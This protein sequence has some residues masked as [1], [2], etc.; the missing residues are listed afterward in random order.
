[1]ERWW[2]GGDNPHCTKPL[3]PTQ[4]RSCSFEASLRWRPS[5]PHPFAPPSWRPTRS[6]W[7]SSG[8]RI[9]HGSRNDNHGWSGGSVP[10]PQDWGEAVGQGLREAG[11][12]SLNVILLFLFLMPSLLIFFIKY[13][14]V[15]SSHGHSLSVLSC[16]CVLCLSVSCLLLTKFV[17]EHISWNANQ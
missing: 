16:L 4:R 3:E 9:P 11:E 8:R 2:Q 13:S 7:R 6:C 10:L 17:T 15:T 14:N 1:M 12:G 5:S